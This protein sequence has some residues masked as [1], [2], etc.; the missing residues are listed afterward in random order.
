MSGRTF[1]M[2]IIKRNPDAVQAQTFE[3]L[4]IGLGEEVFEVLCEKKG[5]SS[6]KMIMMN[7]V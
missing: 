2:A 6:D 4:G 5:V 7:D 1:E 3:E